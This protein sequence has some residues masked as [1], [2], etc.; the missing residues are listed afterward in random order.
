MYI[1]GR[2]PTS[3]KLFSYSRSYPT[4]PGF[5]KQHKTVLSYKLVITILALYSKLTISIFEKKVM[6]KAWKPTKN[7]AVDLYS[8]DNLMY[9]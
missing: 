2:T 5:N 6:K 7:T 4:L 8:Q 3:H 9:N 1:N